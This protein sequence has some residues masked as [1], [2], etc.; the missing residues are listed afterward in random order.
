[1]V[2]IDNVKAYGD[3]SDNEN[4]IEKSTEKYRT[5]CSLQLGKEG[6]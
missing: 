6:M 5:V 2:L 1:M 4:G 3:T